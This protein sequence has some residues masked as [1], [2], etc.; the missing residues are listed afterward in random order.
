[1]T[2]L[3][4][5]KRACKRADDARAAELAALQGARDAGATLQQLA[6][7]RGKTRAGILHML[8]SRG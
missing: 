7:I 8:R 1:M 3:Q 4:A 2:P 6:D 5:Y